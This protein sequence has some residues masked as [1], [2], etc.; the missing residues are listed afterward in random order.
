MLNI[1][2]HFVAVQSAP[3]KTFL[4]VSPNLP[5]HFSEEMRFFTIKQ[6]E[7]LTACVPEI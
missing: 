6:Y 2:F 7:C 3:K 4:R 5:E 1:L